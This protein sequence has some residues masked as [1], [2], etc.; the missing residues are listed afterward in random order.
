[1]CHSPK[2]L[3]LPDVRSCGR[4][5]IMRAILFLAF[6]VAAVACG[7][8]GEPADE[9]SDDVAG[10]SAE[11]AVTN[12]CSLSPSSPRGTLLRCTMQHKEFKGLGG[13]PNGTVTRVYGVFIP[14]GYVA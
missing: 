1:M 13:V 14:K 10:G 2:S 11:S 5:R 8:S 6:C 12:N 7:P 9:S 3:C 4:R